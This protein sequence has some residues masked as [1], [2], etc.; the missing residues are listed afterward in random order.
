MVA[1]GWS[2]LC[3]GSSPHFGKGWYRQL[4]RLLDWTDEATVGFVRESRVGGRYVANF[5]SM[6]KVPRPLRTVIVMED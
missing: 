1:S 5:V 4:S 6:V 3:L 2:I